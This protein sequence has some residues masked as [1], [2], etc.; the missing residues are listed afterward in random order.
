MTSQESHS[1]TYSISNLKSV[2]IYNSKIRNTGIEQLAK[3]MKSRFGKRRNT[4]IKEWLI[5]QL[6][7]GN[8]NTGWAV[9][10]RTLSSTARGV[11]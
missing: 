2:F 9:R 7:A 10:G 3:A 1:R 5:N 11:G 6:C 8:R 4:K